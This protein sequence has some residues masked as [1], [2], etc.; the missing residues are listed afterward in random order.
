MLPTQAASRMQ[1]PSAVTPASHM[2]HVTRLMS[3]APRR[4][5]PRYHQRALA[6]HVRPM[7]T[8][9]PP[10]LLPACMPSVPPVHSPRLQVTPVH[11]PCLQVTTHGWSPVPVTH[12]RSFSSDSW[13]PTR[14][15][16]L[17]TLAPMLLAAY[18]EGDATAAVAAAAAAA[19]G[20][21]HVALLLPPPPLLLLPPSLL[22]LA[23]YPEDAAGAPGGQSSLLPPPLPPS[24]ATSGAVGGAA[25]AAAAAAPAAGDAKGDT[26]AL[27]L[28]VAV[29]RRPSAAAVA[30]ID[31]FVLLPEEAVAA[32][33]A[34]A[35]GEVGGR[36]MA[37]LARPSPRSSMP[38]LVAPLPAASLALRGSITARVTACTAN[39]THWLWA[40]ASTSH[41]DNPRHGGRQCWH[42]PHEHVSGDGYFK[43]F[44]M[45]FIAVPSPQMHMHACAPMH[46]RIRLAPPGHGFSHA[47][48]PAN[49]L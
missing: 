4:P 5:Q 36:A 18:P 2:R 16:M 44:R 32:V 22:L 39:A 47:I 12:R 11:S 14:A 42:S 29:L 13:L 20:G 6:Y 8:T 38:K 17:P 41:P 43:I 19:A 40:A 21:G 45:A 23:A 33:P 34:A 26:A 1:L 9:L 27:L 46:M 49:Q 28:L 37:A 31:L 7:L 24:L 10:M 35:A 30:P 48:S 3:L 15:P 25:A